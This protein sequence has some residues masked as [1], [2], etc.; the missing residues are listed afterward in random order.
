MYRGLYRVSQRSD[1]RYSLPCVCVCV[2]WGTS[3]AMYIVSDQPIM[4]PIGNAL[5]K[6]FQRSR[7]RPQGLELCARK[8]RQT[9][10]KVCVCVFVCYFTC[11]I[12]C[13]CV[14]TTSFEG[15]ATLFVLYDR[16]EKGRAS[17]E[18]GLPIP[19]G[20]PSPTCASSIPRVLNERRGIGHVEAM[21]EAV[22]T[23]HTIR[24]G[25]RVGGQREWH[26]LA[27]SRP[28]CRNAG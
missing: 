28:R 8:T 13:E 1:S 7:A 11:T 20:P 10:Q 21:S 17:D 9:K 15:R 22:I 4:C 24:W 3:R 12:C 14:P 5:H 27:Q 23:Y 18:R 6:T 19:L 2:C 25:G 26:N 16:F